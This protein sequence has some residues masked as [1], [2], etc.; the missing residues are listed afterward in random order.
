[1]APSPFQV[2][3]SER[4]ELSLFGLCVRTDMAGAMKDCSRLWEKDFIAK[5]PELSGKALDQFQGESYGLS[6]M[7][8]PQNGIFDYWA[9]MPLTMGLPRPKNLLPVTLPG[10]LYAGCRVKSLARLGDAYTY[11]YTGWS[12]AQSDYA[13]NMQAPSFELYNHEYVQDGSLQVHV[14]VLRR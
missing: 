5:M 1:M 11:L 9:A 8:D 10:G 13:L 2:T 7:V 14:P 12:A 4:P 6:F 3:L